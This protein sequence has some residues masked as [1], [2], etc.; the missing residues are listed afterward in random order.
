MELL[1]IKIFDNAPEAHV[2]KTKLESLGI[3]AYL[4][5]ENMLSLDPLI[6]IALGGIKLKINKRDFQKAK[7]IITVIEKK[8]LT[9]DQNEIITCPK[10]TSTQL[11]SGFKSVKSMGGIIAMIFSFLFIVYPMYHKNVYKCKQCGKE[12]E[13]AGKIDLKG[14]KL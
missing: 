6:S 10:C 13:E 4:F 14:I 11:Y 9:N 7:G 2:L 3:K 5:D 1:T 12:F 8:P